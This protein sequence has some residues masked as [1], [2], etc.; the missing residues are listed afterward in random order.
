MSDVKDYCEKMHKR[1]IGLKAGLYDVMTKAE[2]VADSVHSEA[3]NN[4]KSLVTNIEAGL[5]ELTNQC[6]SDWSPNKKSLDDNMEQLAKTLGDLAG[7]MG[8]SIPDTTAWL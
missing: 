8:V 4:L 7:H 6:P 5:E 1:L 2:S 3:A